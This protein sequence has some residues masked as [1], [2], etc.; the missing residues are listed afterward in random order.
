MI[1]S[2]IRCRSDDPIGKPGEQMFVRDVGGPAAIPE[3]I[4]WNDAQEAGN[5]V[6]SSDA[7]FWIPNLQGINDLSIICSPR[8]NS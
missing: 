2:T 3:S 5:P 4:P 6:T 7:G 1:D 8:A